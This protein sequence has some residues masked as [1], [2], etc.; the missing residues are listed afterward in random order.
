MRFHKF[1][2]VLPMLGALGLVSVAPT[3]EAVQIR[4]SQES[5]AGLG[6]FDANILGFVSP[7]TSLM[8][9]VQVYQYN[10]PFG[11]SYNG[12]AVGNDGPA[13]L[14]NVSQLFL[15]DASD[16]LSLFIVH[17]APGGGGGT[18]NTQFDLS[19]DTA[20]ILVEDDAEGGYTDTGTQFG[21]AHRWVTCCTDGYVIGSLD[22]NWE[23][24]GQFL[25]SSGLDSWQVTSSGG[26]NIG[27]A[28][29]D[30][31]DDGRRVRLD[32]VPEPAT[33]ALLGIAL[34]GLGASRR[35]QV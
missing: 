16:G 5:V 33:L 15:V 23:M 3:A 12:D 31:D 18:A 17:D 29:G 2:A 21:A 35:R 28:F 32:V 14:S 11:A 7:F 22:G 9:A 13:S 34:V 4:V 24:L 27:L 26:G 10:N 30:E 19:G 25:D 1:I 6:D 20:A 8:T